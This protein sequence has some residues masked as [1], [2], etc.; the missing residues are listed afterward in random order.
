MRK[1]LSILCILTLGCL[2]SCTGEKVPADTFI[3]KGNINGLANEINL[4]YVDSLQEWIFDTI[5]VTNGQFYAEIKLAEAQVAEM[6][7][8]RKFIKRVGAGFAIPT[9]SSSMLFVAQPGQMLEVN[10]DLQQDFVDVYP[11]GDSENDILREYTSVFCPL[12]NAMANLMVKSSTDST[13]TAEDQ[14]T[15]NRQITRYSQ[16][17]QHARIAFLDKHVSSIGGL[18]LLNNMLIDSNIEMDTAERY[19]NKVDKKY[20]HLTY[21]QNIAKRIQGSKATAVGQ[22]A[23]AIRTSR[24]YDGEP[25]DLESWRGKYVLIDF[26][27]TWCGACIAGMPNMKAFAAKHADKLMLLGIAQ[28]SNEDRWRA[29]LDKSAWDWKQIISGTDDEDYVLRY[30][31]QGFPTK[32]LISPE[33]KILKRVVGESPSFY[34]ELEKLIK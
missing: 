19:F 12:E 24:T 16:E 5:K 28:E 34:D 33:G 27:G 13:L 26:W 15:I 22:L 6:S 29:Y 20:A 14:E 1:Y 3:L 7:G 32:I 23:P 11:G 4:M 9:V 17:M 2:A 25:F 18:W 31:V 8:G 10:G 30:N 21:Y